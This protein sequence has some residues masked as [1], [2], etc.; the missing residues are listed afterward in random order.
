MKKERRRNQGKKE[1][2]GQESR[3]HR[4]HNPG[5]ALCLQA[6]P[7]ARSNTGMHFADD[8]AVYKTASSASPHCSRDMQF[9]FG[10]PSAVHHHPLVQQCWTDATQRG[11]A[12]LQPPHSLRVANDGL[13]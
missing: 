9:A 5:A 6:Q 7:R 8:R 1:E 13:W 10:T 2:K 12:G 11:K 3:K 4:I